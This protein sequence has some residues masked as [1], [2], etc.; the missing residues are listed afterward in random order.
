MDRARRSLDRQGLAILAAAFFSAENLVSIIIGGIVSIG[1]SQWL[2]NATNAY[3]P[4]MLVVSVIISIIVA[5]VAMAVSSYLGGTSISWGDLGQ[6]GP[7]VFALATIG[8]KLFIADGQP[9]S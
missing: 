3:G 1:L 9:S 7:Q 5:V 8:Y 2:K 4:V 6:L